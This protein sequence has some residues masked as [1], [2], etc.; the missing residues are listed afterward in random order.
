M[1]SYLFLLG[2]GANRS[3]THAQRHTRQSDQ[4]GGRSRESSAQ[5]VEALGKLC[6]CW[7]GV[8]VLG[9]CGGP[10]RSRRDA[11]LGLCAR[12]CAERGA[13]IDCHCAHHA[14]S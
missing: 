6:K 9:R 14:L 5:P 7:S 2:C 11:A 12:V 13:I 8:C 1:R 4:H 10:S 3:G